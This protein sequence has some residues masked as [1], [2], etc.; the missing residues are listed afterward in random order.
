MKSQ[1]SFFYH[2]VN[3]KVANK[4]I[5]KDFLFTLAKF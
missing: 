1:R 4:F 3:Y 2:I 5:L